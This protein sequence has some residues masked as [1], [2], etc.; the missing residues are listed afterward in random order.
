MPPSGRTSYVNYDDRCTIV[1]MH[2]NF[3]DT[4]YQGDWLRELMLV[5]DTICIPET[6]LLVY[7]ARKRGCQTVNGVEMLIRQ[8][9]RQFEL[10]TKRSA[11]IALMRETGR[12][13]ISSE[14]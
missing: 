5:F 3:D 14:S 12:R 9:A 8:A 4:P 10:F 11:P 1:G 13:G 2:L 7:Q 6:T